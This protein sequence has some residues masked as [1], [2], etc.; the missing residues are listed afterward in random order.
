MRRASAAERTRLHETFA[1]LC[2]IESPSGVERTC[3]DWVSAELRGMGIEVE[4]DGSGPEVGSDSG[5]LL[6][7][8][9]GASTRSIL[10]CA[11]LD[12]VPPT[13]PIEPV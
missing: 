7:R 1:A 10:L 3:A 5:N 12:T 11:H 6:A 8:I 2:L 4:E 9:P 13:A